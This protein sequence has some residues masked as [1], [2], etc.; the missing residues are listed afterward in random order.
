[1]WTLTVDAGQHGWEAGAAAARKILVQ[2]RGVEIIER[3]VLQQTR[4]RWL[5]MGVQ[6][7]LL[8]AASDRVTQRKRGQYCACSACTVPCE[9]DRYFNFHNSAG[10]HTEEARFESWLKYWYLY[11]ASPKTALWW[12]IKRQQYIFKYIRE[13]NLK[14]VHGW[15]FSTTSLWH[16]QDSAVQCPNLPR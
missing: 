1:M 12:Y 15:L 9:L 5:S 2:G 6:T 8:S 4:W 10:S 11:A 16:L 7:G 14:N 13:N 3:T